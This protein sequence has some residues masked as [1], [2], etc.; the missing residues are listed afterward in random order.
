VKT[1]SHPDASG[2]HL[3]NHK[4]VLGDVIAFRYDHNLKIN[5]KIPGFGVDGKALGLADGIRNHDSDIDIL[6][7]VLGSRGPGSE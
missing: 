2:F 4:G 1:S 3:V 5:V 7:V 6:E